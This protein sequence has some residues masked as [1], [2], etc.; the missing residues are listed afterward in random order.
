MQVWEKYT[1][2][3]KLL[4]VEEASEESK[5]DG[6]KKITRRI[7]CSTIAENAEM[8]AELLNVKPV[9]FKPSIPNLVYQYNFYTNFEPT[10][11]GEKNPEIP[12]FDD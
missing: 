11:L 6:D 12:D 7:L 2:A 5:D 9:P 8:M 4:L 10:S 1:E 3:A